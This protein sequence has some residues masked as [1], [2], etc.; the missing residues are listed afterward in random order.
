MVI[1][2][3]DIGSNLDQEIERGRVN[4]FVKFLELKCVICGKVWKVIK[5]LITHY[6]N[7]HGVENLR[8]LKEK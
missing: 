1:V 2:V 3:W 5:A 4:A 7:K 6:K 8:R